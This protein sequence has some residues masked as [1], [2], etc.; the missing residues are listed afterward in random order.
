MPF[1]VTIN[2]DGEPQRAMRYVRLNQTPTDFGHPGNGHFQDGEINPLAQQDLNY[3]GQA[4][5]TAGGSDMP[6]PGQVLASQNDWINLHYTFAGD[7]AGAAASGGCGPVV[8]VPTDELT[9]EDVEWMDQNYP[10]PP[11]LADFD[12]DGQVGITDFLALLAAW[13][14]NEAQYDLAL[15]GN[16]VVG[17]EDF[18]AL[19]AQWGPCPL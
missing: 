18:L 4:A 12:G 17:I 6:S 8:T 9:L 1:G 13:G 7:E 2:V 10:I 15:P 16:D 14:S 19:L 11:C 5:Y 3:L